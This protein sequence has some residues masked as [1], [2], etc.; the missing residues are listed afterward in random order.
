MT[1]EEVRASQIKLGF[2]EHGNLLPDNRPKVETVSSAKVVGDFVAPGSAPHVSFAD[3]FV[4]VKE[5]PKTDT[6]AETAVREVPKVV[7]DR[8]AGAGLD[9]EDGENM[10]EV[11]P[12]AQA[13]TREEPKKGVTVKPIPEEKGASTLDDF[14]ALKA[15]ILRLQEQQ[16]VSRENRESAQQRADD[17]AKKASDVK[18]QLEIS[19]ASYDERM[20]KL[21]KYTE[22]LQAACEE[23]ERYTKEA[24]RSARESETFIQQQSDA[25]AANKRKI[26]EIDSMLGEAPTEET[27]LAIVK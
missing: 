24:E 9:L 3:T 1:D 6:T 16:R 21:R 15:K 7:P 5:Q 18:K 17:A 8:E 4:P 14:T 20:A 19:Q 2:D 13:E 10:F 26:E 25:V 27:A 12:E 23:E 22:K 11:I